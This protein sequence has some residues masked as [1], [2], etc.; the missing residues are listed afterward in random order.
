MLEPDKMKAAGDAMRETGTR[1]AEAGTNVSLK[2]LD[3]AEENTRQAFAAMRAAAQ[4][5]SIGDVMK[6][7]ADYI[8]E[9][10]SRS[11][12]QVREIGD[13]IVNFGREAMAPLTGKKQGKDGEA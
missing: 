7:Q 12:S 5:G 10:S 11:M 1:A 3:Q 4:A 6:V 13:L 2:L 8:R 9:Q